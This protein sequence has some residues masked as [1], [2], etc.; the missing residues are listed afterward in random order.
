[1]RPRI[2]FPQEQSVVFPGIPTSIPLAKLPAV[3]VN[4][5]ARTWWLKALGIDSICICLSCRDNNVYW[6]GKWSWTIYPPRFRVCSYYYRPFNIFPH[7]YKVFTDTHFDI[8]KLLF[9]KSLGYIEGRPLNV[10]PAYFPP[11]S[12]SPFNLI[13]TIPLGHIHFGGMIRIR[14]SWI[15]K[16]DF[17]FFDYRIVEISAQIWYVSHIFFPLSHLRD[18]CSLPA[19]STMNVSPVKSLDL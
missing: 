1:M 15:G 3:G 5:I 2:F 4:A 19:D 12:Y 11:N 6:F 10:A 13:E 16:V 9:G 8:L 14:N 7:L 18:S 17:F